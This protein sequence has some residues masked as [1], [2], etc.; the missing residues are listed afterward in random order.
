MSQAA[1]EA[2][3]R[4]LDANQDGVLDRDEFGKALRRL[5]VVLT[6]SEIDSLWGCMDT[7]KDGRVDYREFVDALFHV[8]RDEL[9][10]LL[11]DLKSRFHSGARGDQ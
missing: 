10:L 8:R 7:D 3:F 2:L 6:D 1:N 11:V 9:P 5:D 4:K